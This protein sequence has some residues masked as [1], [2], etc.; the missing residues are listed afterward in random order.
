M[1]F[2]VREFVRRLDCSQ[3]WRDP[4]SVI[5]GTLRTWSFGTS[6]DVFLGRGRP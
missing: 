4:G 6:S 1:Q 2:R 3:E 5:D